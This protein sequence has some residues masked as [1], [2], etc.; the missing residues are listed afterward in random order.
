M[1]FDRQAEVSVL[2]LDSFVKQN[3]ASFIRNVL[4]I[5]IV[6]FKAKVLRIKQQKWTV[7]LPRLCLQSFGGISSVENHVKMIKSCA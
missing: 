7:V 6:N 3:K 1:A 4:E 2:I 5:E